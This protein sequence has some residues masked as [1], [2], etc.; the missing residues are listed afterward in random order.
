LW[1]TYATAFDTMSQFE[2]ID[3]SRMKKPALVDK[4]TREQLIGHWIFSDEKV[5][6]EYTFKADGTFT[7]NIA[8]DGTVVWEMA[9][10]WS[11]D[12]SIINYEITKSSEDQVGTGARDQDR[13]TGIAKDYYMVDA[14]NGGQRKFVRVVEKDKTS[15]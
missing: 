13:I 7:G 5:S 10:K 15:K 6:S 11:L 3:L 12:G 1:K 2:P 8:Q 14:G 9:G 4:V